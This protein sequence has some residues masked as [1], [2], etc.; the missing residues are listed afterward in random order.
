[1]NAIKGFSIF[2]LMTLCAQPASAL[3][4]DF[5]T[6]GGFSETVLAFQR[7]SLIFSNANYGPMIFIAAAFGIFWGGSIFFYRSLSEMSSG[8]PLKFLAVPIIGVVIYQGV[9]LP[10]GTIHIYDPTRNAYEA[11]GNVPDLLVLLAGGWNK[12][13]RLAAEIEAGSSAYPYHEAAGG[14]G[15]NLL[16]NISTSR[17]DFTEHYLIKSLKSFYRDCSEVPAAIANSGF[18][19]ETLKSG[20]NDIY[21]YLD[22]IAWSST[23]TSYYDMTTKGGRAVTCREAWVDHLKPAL[24]VSSFFDRPLERICESAGFNAQSAAQLTTCKGL[25]DDLGINLFEVNSGHISLMRNALISQII[26]EAMANENPDVATRVMTNRDMMTD[27]IGAAINS[28]EWVFTFR[29][30]MLTTVL[31]LIPVLVV[32]LVTP[33][34]FKSLFLIFGLLAWAAVWGIVDIVCNGIAIDQSLR[35]MDEIRIHGLGLESFIAAPTGAMKAMAIF[36]KIRSYGALLSTVIVTSLFGISAYALSGMASSMQQ[37]MEKSGTESSDKSFNPEDRGHQYSSLSSGQATESTVARM[38]F[39]AVAS[40]ASFRHGTDAMTSMVESDLL[41]AGGLDMGGAMAAASASRGGEIYG[42]TSATM[43]ATGVAPP[44]GFEMAGGTAGAIAST[45]ANAAHTQRTMNLASNEGIVRASR[46]SGVPLNQTAHN[47]GVMSYLSNLSD[48]QILE[49]MSSNDILSG[50]YGNG[51]ASVNGGRIMDGVATQYDG[52]KG[53]FFEDLASNRF[54]K[55]FAQFATAAMLAEKLDTGVFESSVQMNSTGFSVAVTQDNFHELSAGGLLTPAQENTIAKTIESGQPARLDFTFDPATGSIGDSTASSGNRAI[56]NS[57]TTISEAKLF[58]RSE[59][60]DMSTRT[61]SSTSINS[62]HNEDH[63]FNVQAQSIQRLSLNPKL[64][65][66]LANVF[67]LADDGSVLTSAEELQIDKGLADVMATVVSKQSMEGDGYRLNA[68]AGVSGRFGLSVDSSN[69][70]LGKI[71]SIGTGV[72]AYADANVSVQ[73]GAGYHITGADSE[74]YQA[75]LIDAQQIRIS[76]MEEGMKTA[77]QQVLIENRN[78][79]SSGGESLTVEE[80]EHRRDELKY[81][82]AAQFYQEG[83]ESWIEKHLEKSGEQS[84]D[85]KTEEI[86]E[87]MRSLSDRINSSQAISELPSN[88]IKK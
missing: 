20:T 53:Q 8:F 58:D 39:S 76:S 45:A 27:G 65:D 55:D 31:G 17:D 40:S 82:Y 80:M 38:G 71:A 62:S 56:A 23:S 21:S 36:G 43:A 48:S 30:V 33:L 24:A 60:V 81:E 73:G 77:Q 22:N 26:S 25:I 49:S 87:K 16:F 12:F 41:R 57:N 51:M 14:L 78:I 5:Y 13:E 74:Y 47:T 83:F 67:R 72:K 32:F 68:D 85:L 88:I 3:D 50:Y 79:I 37:T 70:L 2:V 15:F 9:I 69:Q 75:N 11:V 54:G 34:A 61:D 7:V 35:V 66:E 46:D 64:Q 59:R 18:D 10:K 44:I 1:M 28:Q 42:G 19:I 4:L 63:G 84:S 29:S 86:G 52:G 6:Y